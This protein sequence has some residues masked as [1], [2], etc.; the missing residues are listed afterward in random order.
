MLNVFEITVLIL[1]F[2]LFLFLI[3]NKNYKISLIILLIIILLFLI[4][5]QSSIIEKYSNENELI[6]DLKTF[7]FNVL[8][9]LKDKITI[10][11]GK[12]S[13]T[14]NKKNIYI[15]VYDENKKIYSK[16]ILYNVLLHELAHVISPTISGT[17]ET[18]HDEI[19]YK[20]L[21]KLNEIAISKGY[22]NINFNVVPMSYCVKKT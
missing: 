5:L 3:K 12:S 7:A 13:L 10:N 4:K 1:L 17:N 6:N 21:V 11:I 8:P 20:N 2:I 22:L 18:N 16:D 15:C 14:E 9:N 19:H